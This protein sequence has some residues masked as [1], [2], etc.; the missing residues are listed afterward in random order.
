MSGTE[1]DLI[2]YRRYDCFYCGC[3]LY[4]RPSSPFEWADLHKVFHNECAER[5]IE[6]RVQEVCGKHYAEAPMAAVSNTRL[7]TICGLL[8]A[9]AISWILSMGITIGYVSDGRVGTL[10]PLIWALSFGLFVTAGLLAPR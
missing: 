1:S 4:V 8:A 7:R 6:R 10:G 9:A 2:E 5:Y 3:P